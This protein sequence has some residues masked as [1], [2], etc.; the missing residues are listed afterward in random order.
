MNKLE[1]I[2]KMRGLGWDAE[3]VK[4]VIQQVENAAKQGIDIP[5]EMFAHKFPVREYPNFGKSLKELRNK[6]KEYRKKR[7]K[8]FDKLEAMYADDKDF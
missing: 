4:E 2:R 3:Y 6:E 5:Y 1:F 7:E 8:E